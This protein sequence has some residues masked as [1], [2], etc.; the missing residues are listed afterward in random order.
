MIRALLALAGLA[1]LWSVGS[2]VLRAVAWF[3]V[4]AIALSL[5]IGVDVPGAGPAIAGGCWLGAE[6]LFRLR[7]GFWRSRLLARATGRPPAVLV[8]GAE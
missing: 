4:A 8:D 1:L 6:V 2:V 5:V 3:T 7:Q